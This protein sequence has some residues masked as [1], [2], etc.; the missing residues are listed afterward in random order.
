MVGAV[1]RG[2]NLPQRSRRTKY[3]FPM[4]AKKF[5]NSFLRYFCAAFFSAAKEFCHSL[6]EILAISIQQ[7]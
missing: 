1:P 5:S 3:A 6:R 7:Q 4:N 2:P